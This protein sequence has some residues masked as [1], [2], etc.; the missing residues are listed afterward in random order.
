MQI[1]YLSGA[2]ASLGPAF[3]GTDPFV[4]F[5]PYFGGNAT[6]LLARSCPQQQYAVSQFSVT[7]P[8]A[9]PP[10]TTPALPPGPP[11]TPA[12]PA[13]P[14]EAPHSSRIEGA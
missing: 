1:G 10:L 14:P 8:P 4:A 2:Y 13:S 12:P 5:R 9:P 3:A 6:T 11:Q 7:M